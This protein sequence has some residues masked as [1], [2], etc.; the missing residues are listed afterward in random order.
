VH[1]SA[2][3]APRAV[4]LLRRRQAAILDVLRPAAA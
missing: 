3:D 1:A 4:A 2:P